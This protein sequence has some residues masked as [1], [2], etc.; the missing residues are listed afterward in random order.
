MV[1]VNSAPDKHTVSI[2]P[3]KKGLHHYTYPTPVSCATWIEWDLEI[4]EYDIDFY[5][6]AVCDGH[7]GRTIFPQRQA[8]GTSIRWDGKR[9]K[10][11][12]P[13]SEH[14]EL[15]DRTCGGLQPTPG[16]PVTIRFVFSNQT[17]WTRERN[18]KYA[19][20]G[21]PLVA[22][23]DAPEAA[24]ELSA[25]GAAINLVARRLVELGAE[26]ALG[27][28]DMRHML[29]QPTSQARD[30]Q[31]VQDEQSSSEAPITKPRLLLAVASCAPTRGPQPRPGYHLDQPYVRVIKG[32]SVWQTANTAALLAVSPAAAVLP[33]PVIA[34]PEPGAEPEPAPAPKVAVP[35]PN[36][37]RS[38]IQ[39]VDMVRT[40]LHYDQA[41]KPREVIAQAA[42]DLGIG[43]CTSNI[44]HDLS[45]R[46]I[47]E[48]VLVATRAE[49]RRWE[50]W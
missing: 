43:K 6:E 11:G 30:S 37:R 26:G 8:E 35:A 48:C 28:G 25:E 17:S 46:G 44:H 1:R 14:L 23:D 42:E 32:L 10:A 18:I 29:F 34:A 5:I 47:S 3:G 50:A 27:E 45:F 13:I 16:T 38:F 4:E 12:A 7:A 49:R 15:T 39:L 24:V 9:Y 22:A 21:W 41:L 40:E 20:R 33:V 31:R 2:A 19:V 36:T